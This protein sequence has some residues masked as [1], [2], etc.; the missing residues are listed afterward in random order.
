MREFY[1]LSS[2]TY[3]DYSYCSHAVYM[4]VDCHIMYCI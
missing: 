2:V 1:M 4:C 3:K